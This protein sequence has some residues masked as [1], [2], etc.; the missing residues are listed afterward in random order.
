MLMRI[1]VIVIV[2]LC[3]YLAPAARGQSAVDVQKIAERLDRLEKQNQD[4]QTEVQELRRQLDSSQQTTVAQSDQP[5][6]PDNSPTVAERLDVQ[7]SR[8][9]ELAQS[10]VGTSQRMPVSLT[11]MIL[12]NAFH[13]G[14]YGGPLQVPV[15]AQVNPTPASTG[16]TLRQTVIGLK[17]NGPD[18]PGW[19]QGHRPPRISISGG[20]TASPGN[21][22]FRVRLATLD[23]TWENF[24]ITVGQDKPIVSPREPMS[25]AQVGLA[26]LS[27]AGNLWNWQPQLRV[28]QRFGNSTTGVRAQ[29][30]I[31]QTAEVLCAGVPA[32][33]RGHAGAAA[34]RPQ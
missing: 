28:E 5:T 3:V 8:T 2:G 7:E 25:L 15:T 6:P 21:N 9:E 27:G 14:A 22:L 16:A 10:K 30:G 33:D 31:Y 4:L 20:G 18:L 19:R 13:N 32:L 24:T 12:F 34:P 29:A 23:L 17:F 1:P 11:G 26:P